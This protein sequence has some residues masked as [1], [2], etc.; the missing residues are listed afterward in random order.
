MAGVRAYE[1]LTRYFH[2]IAEG[3]LNSAAGTTS[4][5]TALAWSVYLPSIFH[6][7]LTY[8]GV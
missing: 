1:L 3:N 2:L 8:T 4:A 6:L 7:Q 5:E